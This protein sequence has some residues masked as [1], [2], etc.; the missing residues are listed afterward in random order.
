[1]INLVADRRH[2]RDRARRRPERAA[3]PGR[4]E[5]RRAPERGA[6]ARPL[7]QSSLRP[8]DHRLE[9]RDPGAR[10]ADGARFLPSLL[11]AEQRRAGR[12]RRRDAGGGAPA[13]RGHL[14]QDPRAAGGGA[15]AAPLRAAGDRRRA[16]ITVRDEKV[17]EPQLQRAYVVPSAVTAAPG[18]SGGA[19]PAR[20]NSRRRRHQ[21]LLRRAR[22][23][24]WR[25]DLCRRELPLER[26]R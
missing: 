6:A 20:R 3:R 10:P 14:R 5:P 21:P 19:Q 25:G 24:R 8:A 26:P 16:S 13:R 15:R 4:E 18:R 2:G 11:H 1:M 17:R 7:P 9:P 23:R 22:A 12:R